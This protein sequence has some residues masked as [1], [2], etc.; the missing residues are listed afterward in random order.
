M[1]GVIYIFAGKNIRI[2]FMKAIYLCV[3]SDRGHIQPVGNL[4]LRF[5][6]LIF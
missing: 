1:R 2:A 5:L 3:L 4:V 6:A